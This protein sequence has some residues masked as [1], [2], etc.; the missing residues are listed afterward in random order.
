MLDVECK[1]IDCNVMREMGTQQHMDNKH[2]LGKPAK[3]LERERE[4][5]ELVNSKMYCLR[6]IEQL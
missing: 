5:E 4:R 1:L 3:A 6:D 2:S